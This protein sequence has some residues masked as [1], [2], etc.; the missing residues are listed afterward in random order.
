MTSDTLNNCPRYILSSTGSRRWLLHLTEQFVID[1]RHFKQLYARAPA[2]SSRYGGKQTYSILPRW[3]CRLVLE[4]SQIRRI[5]ETWSSLKHRWWCSILY[6]QR[7]ISLASSSTDSSN[8]H[9]GSSREHTVCGFSFKTNGFWSKLYW[10]W[11]KLELNYG[12][13]ETHSTYRNYKFQ[14]SFTTNMFHDTSSH[15]P[16]TSWLNRFTPQ[17]FMV[18]SHTH[19]NSDRREPRETDLNGHDIR[20]WLTD[21]RRSFLSCYFT[22]AGA[23]WYSN[24]NMT[25]LQLYCDWVSSLHNKNG[26]ANLMWAVVVH[27]AMIISLQ[28]IPSKILWSSGSNINWKEWS[29]YNTTYISLTHSL[30]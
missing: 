30:G 3:L 27:I 11:S 4:T 10:L 12:N 2:S 9:A 26:A 28:M 22:L 24:D 17:Y 5:F 8:L 15:S 23:G 18:F 20:R 25:S 14:L 13:S 19:H 1:Q 21:I 16:K 7:K 29:G 6:E